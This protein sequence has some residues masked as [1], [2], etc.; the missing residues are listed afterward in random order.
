MRCLPALCRIAF[1]GAALWGAA[2]R[3]EPAASRTGS[4]AIARVEYAASRAQSH[5]ATR[6][7]TTTDRPDSAATHP[8]ITTDR[9][10]SAAREI[11][12]EAAGSRSAVP[13]RTGRGSTDPLPAARPLP[14]P[15]P[16]PRPSARVLRQTADDIT[17]WC[18][19]NPE[20]SLADNLCSWW[21]DETRGCVEVQLLRADSAA[22]SD[23][24]RR[25]SD[26]PLIRLGG[27]DPDTTPYPPAPAGDTPPEGLTM[28]AEQAF[29][30]SGTERVRLTI[31][32]R[33]GG[34]IFFGTEYT[35]SRFQ[36]GRWEVLPVCG[37]WN[38]L[39]IRLGRPDPPA[40]GL[41]GPVPP[42]GWT[43]K[44]TAWLAPR[45]FPARYG[46]Y[47]VSKRVRAEHPRREYL[48]ETEF[49]VTP[50]IPFGPYTEAAEAR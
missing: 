10:D 27:F 48:L 1:W 16:V 20:D 40:P 44:F 7:G 22:R 3:A 8:C 11:P 31:R 18:R 39:L 33:G 28:R 21:T 35:V 37:A 4:L 6:P 13:I 19:A 5:T 41:Q 12:T 14:S 2:V 32:Y 25:V 42:E 17:R 29:Y 34:T 36:H 30:P 43:H 46:R 24:R 49:T 9:S 38:S 45:V 23:F 50:F 15:R 47:R 26:S